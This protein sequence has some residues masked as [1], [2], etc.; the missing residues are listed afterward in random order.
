[1]EQ[2]NASEKSEKDGLR[3]EVDM[4]EREKRLVADE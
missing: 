4:F 1:M 2:E 3:V